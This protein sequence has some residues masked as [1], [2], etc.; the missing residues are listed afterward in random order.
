[1]VLE[2]EGKDSL[3]LANVPL[4]QGPQGLTEPQQAPNYAVKFRTLNTSQSKDHKAIMRF[5]SCG[6][7]ERERER[8]REKKRAGDRK[9]YTD[10]DRHR[11]REKEI[12]ING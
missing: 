8:E 11:E 1:M 3:P 2:V 9:I 6:H 7:K 10:R 12:E 5:I 4:E